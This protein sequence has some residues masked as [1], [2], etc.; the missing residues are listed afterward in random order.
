MK[1]EFEFAVTE[2]LILNQERPA[3]PRKD[4]CKD[5]PGANKSPRDRGTQARVICN[6]PLRDPWPYLFILVGAAF[7]N[8]NE[9]SFNRIQA[10]TPL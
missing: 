5:I 4:S 10:R 2:L 9:G 1:I 7:S 3:G 8:L 6:Y